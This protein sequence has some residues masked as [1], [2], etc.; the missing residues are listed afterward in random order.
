MRAGAVLV[1]GRGAHLAV[2]LAA[3]DEVQRLVALRISHD[4]KQGKISLGQLW[5]VGTCESVAA[6]LAA[7]DGV[8]RL[9]GCRTGL[10]VTGGDKFA[11]QERSVW[12]V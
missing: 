9:A 11:F 10:E 8:Q 6:G 3:G 5:S 2:G 12:H 7:Q 4:R 1:E